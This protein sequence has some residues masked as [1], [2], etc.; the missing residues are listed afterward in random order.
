[1]SRTA[2]IRTPEIRSMPIFLIDSL[3]RATGV[4][5]ARTTMTTESQTGAIKFA[6]AIGNTGGQSMTTQSNID[7]SSTI[8]CFRRG[9]L[10]NSTGFSVEL[11]HGRKD[12]F[13][14]EHRI[15]Q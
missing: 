3:T 7:A 12:K 15:R 11:P 6:S 14:S 8:N 13:N 2:F 10:S 1:M 5:S 4:L 9:E